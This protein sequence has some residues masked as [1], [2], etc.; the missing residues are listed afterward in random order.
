MENIILFYDLY[1][2]F[3]LLSEDELKEKLYQIR[4]NFNDQFDRHKVIEIGLIYYL[5][6][7]FDIAYSYF[8]KNY[9]NNFDCSLS[10]FLAAISLVKRQKIDLIADEV[11][12]KIEDL[13]K[14]AIL[15]NDSALYNYCLYIIY[16]EY[17]YKKGILTQ[18][19][20]EDLEMKCNALKIT[21]DDKRIANELFL[22]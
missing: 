6:K 4:E 3:K 7:H 2:K 15:I 1:N 20:I 12:V 8:K 17:Y 13:L 14:G 11:I 9:I 22:T 10:Y 5:L 16:K 18:P 19:S 21:E